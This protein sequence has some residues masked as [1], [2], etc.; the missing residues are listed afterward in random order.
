[1]LPLMV[2]NNHLYTLKD[3]KRLFIG[4]R[5]SSVNGEASADVWRRAFGGDAGAGCD[6]SA[7]FYYSG[8]GG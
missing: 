7:S 2:E 1:M 3:E 6:T 5:L 4:D 8:N